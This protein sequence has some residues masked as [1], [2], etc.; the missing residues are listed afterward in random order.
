MAT[1]TWACY[2]HPDRRAGVSC[3]RCDRPICPECMSQA[4][5]G[6]HCPECVRSG[7]QKV[8]TARS[9]E[10]R[11]LLTQAL[12]AVNV[13]VFVVGLLFPGSVFGT[14]AGVLNGEDVAAGDW[15]RPLTSGFLHATIAHLAFNM[16]ALWILGNQLESALGRL[17]FAIVYF[18]SLLGG[19]LGALLLSPSVNTVGASGAIF[20]LMGTAAAAHVIRGVSVWS[21]GLGAILVV[22]L[23][24]TFLYPR[25]SIGGHLGGLVVGFL[26]GLLVIEEP[27]GSPRAWLAVGGGA[28]A[29]V[30]LFVGGLAISGVVT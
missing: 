16:I 22:N 23:L 7:R 29:A 9:L 30:A 1:E 4:P 19:A 12:I 14:G 3:Q 20:G 17:R 10:V 21:T 25:I 26:L 11:P 8:I 5:V 18:G 15:W 28:A 27:R 2:R 13:A 6:F 24:G